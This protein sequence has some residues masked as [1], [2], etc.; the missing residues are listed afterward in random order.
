MNLK[1]QLKTQE[2]DAEL[3]R[4]M[5]K[6]ARMEIDRIK[7]EIAE[8]EKPKLRH[9]DVRLFDRTPASPMIYMADS[10][11]NKNGLMSTWENCEKLPTKYNFFDDLKALQEPLEEF[12]IKHGYPCKQRVNAGWS[13]QPSGLLYVGCGEQGTTRSFHFSAGEL[14][15]FILNLRRMQATQERKAKKES[16]GQ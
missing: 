16:A 5:A 4:T 10:W 2:A 12:E 15:E 13:I 7:A 11:Y 8:A 1:E 6:R 14:D 9:G 3:H